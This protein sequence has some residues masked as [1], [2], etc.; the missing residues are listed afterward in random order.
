MARSTGKVTIGKGVA[1]LLR[2]VVIDLRPTGCANRALPVSDHARKIP[3]T[4][5]RAAFDEWRASVTRPLLPWPDHAGAPQSDGNPTNLI[6]EVDVD[7][8]GHF[9]LP[10]RESWRQIDHEAVE[11][12][13]AAKE[14]E[15]SL[16]SAPANRWSRHTRTSI[17]HERR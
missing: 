15:T 6:V 11:H 16:K 3:N 13:Q 9:E 8:G 12:H 1:S 17:G 5:L 7:R 10:S 4:A 2:L 14:A